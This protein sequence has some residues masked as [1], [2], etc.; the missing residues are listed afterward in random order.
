MRLGILKL[1]LSPA[2]CISKASTLDGGA[3][4]AYNKNTEQKSVLI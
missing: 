1:T 3:L 2:S 4:S